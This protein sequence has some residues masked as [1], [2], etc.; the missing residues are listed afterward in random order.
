MKIIID[1]N[2]LHGALARIKP[3]IGRNGQIVS[4]SGVLLTTDNLDWLQFDATDMR[5]RNSTRTEATCDSSNHHL[6]IPFEQFA[7]LVGR[8][9]TGNVT[10]QWDDHAS[11]VDIRAGRIKA[12]L[13][14]MDASTFPKLCS[15][16]GNAVELDDDWQA[17]RRVIHARGHDISRP[18][19]TCLRLGEGWATT[20]DS[21]RLARHPISACEHV[22]GEA[23]PLDLLLAPMAVEAALRTCPAGPVT[24]RW[25][26]HWYSIES[27]G[28][29]WTAERSDADYPTASQMDRQF[30]EPQASFTVARNQLIDALDAVSSIGGEKLK[31]DDGHTYTSTLVNL[32]IFDG[33]ICVAS[34]AEAGAIEVPLDADTKGI[35][36]LAFNPTFLRPALNACADET[37]TMQGTDP[38]KPWS[39]IDGELQQVVVPVRVPR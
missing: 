29:T 1:R 28:T 17:I 24:L 38:I 35:A 30:V 34:R 36:A 18:V 25:D 39:L 5:V 14:L 21:Y 26:E 4:T 19:L 9:P 16:E 23:R 6:L 33:S 32:D 12:S 11:E 15:V 2:Q 13:S 37:I 20:T 7:A 3:A 31:A 10:L 8:C 22:D 27:E